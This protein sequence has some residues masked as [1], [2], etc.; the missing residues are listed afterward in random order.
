MLHGKQ[1]ILFS[2]VDILAKTKIYFHRMYELFQIS[3]SNPKFQ[4]MCQKQYM[5]WT[6]PQWMNSRVEILQDT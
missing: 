3:L 5:M 4:I 2:K 1:I 6:L